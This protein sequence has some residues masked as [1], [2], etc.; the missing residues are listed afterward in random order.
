M[1]AD[2]LLALIVFAAAASFTP[3][4]N[5]AIA[6]VTGANFGLRAVVPHMFGV[7]F[8]FAS[9]L[10]AAAGGVAAL[11]LAA[12]LAAAIL[13]WAGIAYLLWL[14]WQLAQPGQATNVSGPFKLPLSFAQSA[15]FQY[16]NP[17][18]W[19]FALAATTAYVTGERPSLRAAIVVFVCALCAFA[20]L[21]TWGWIGAALRHWLTQGARLRVFNLTMA[22]TLALTAL[23]MGLATTS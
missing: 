23:W 7:P 14:A 16:L 3:G 10:L 1:P 9:M 13:K 19:M 2:Q 15:L 6:T 8:G 11:V 12:P 17:K 4:P 21:L 20:S 18:A 22:V 5:N